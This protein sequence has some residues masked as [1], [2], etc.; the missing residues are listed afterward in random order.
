M[1]IL[2]EM[3]LTEPA[4][5]AIWGTL[6]LFTLPAL[7]VLANPDGVRNPHLALRDTA[8]FV[9]LHRER[10]RERR[11]RWEAETAQAVRYAQEVRVAATQAA[12]AV[13]RW[14]AHWQAASEQVDAAWSAWQAADA[15]WARSRA[16]AAFGA[17]WTPRNP[18]EYADRER[19]LHRRLRS[20][21]SCGELPVTA[22][23]DV[24][25][26]ATLHPV[27][28]EMA[29]HQAYAAHREWEHAAAVAAERAAW[30]DVQLSRRSRDSL[31]REAAR[32]EAQALVTRSRPVPSGFAVTPGRGYV[33]AG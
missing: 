2:A 14:Q 21:V 27:E 32:A 10:Q 19:F 9:R 24:R 7:V 17:P 30:H 13:D 18:A 26:D 16:T 5:M 25:W 29:L 23:A 20:A 15:R 22:P 31:L 11:A 6:M 3:L 4:P 28:Q 12:E 33:S 8:N 1:N